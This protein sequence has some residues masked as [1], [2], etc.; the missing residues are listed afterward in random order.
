MLQA[1]EV[2]QLAASV[3]DTVQNLCLHGRSDDAIDVLRS[4]LP[5]FAK[6]HQ[7]LR[8]PDSAEFLAYQYLMIG[9]RVCLG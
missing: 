3:G 2:E 9:S 8:T 5:A 4:T 1:R 6:A 7:R